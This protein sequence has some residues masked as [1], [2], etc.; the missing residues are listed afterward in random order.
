MYRNTAI[1]SFPGFPG[2]RALKDTEG[3]GPQR[4]WEPFAV[5]LG[6]GTCSWGLSEE[7]TP[8]RLA[9]HIEQTLQGRALLSL[10]IEGVVQRARSLIGLRGV[11]IR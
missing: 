9:E 3:E 8:V 4:D 1:K 6:R 11:I 10:A 7:P 5:R 2:C